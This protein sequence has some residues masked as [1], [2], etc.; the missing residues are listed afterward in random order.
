MAGIKLLNEAQASSIIESGK[1]LRLWRWSEY[2]KQKL[3][4]YVPKTELH[5][6][7]LD[8]P[9]SARSSLERVFTRSMKPRAEA[10]V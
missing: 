1:A 3:T 10:A 8:V 4:E 7:D 9:E 2:E 6:A 5:N